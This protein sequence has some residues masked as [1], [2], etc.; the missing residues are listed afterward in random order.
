MPLNIQSDGTYLLDSSSLLGNDSVKYIPCSNR[1]K[2][3]VCNGMVPV[4]SNLEEGNFCFACSLNEVIPDLRI[5]AHLPLWKHLE[6][7]KRRTVFT[8]KK[9]KLPIPTIKQAPK[10]GLSFY[11][12][13]DSHAKDHF[14]IKL[15]GL[16]PVF[17][18]H[19]QGKIT[20][21]LAEADEVSRVTVKNSLDEGYRTLLG[22]FRHEIG[23][24]YWDVLVQ[25]NAP[26]LEE[27]RATFGDDRLDYQEAMKQHYSN[28]AAADWPDHF[29]SAYATMHPWEDWAET[30][31]HYLHMVDCLSTAES[32]DLIRLR[33][34]KNAATGSELVY[35]MEIDKLVFSWME[36]SV[37]LNALNR[38]MGLE[39][40]YPFVL[41]ASVRKKLAFIHK[42]IN[43]R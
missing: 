8:L 19:D 38:S 27:C 14:Q 20:I 7:A 25:N 2:Y 32:H 15:P 26:L 17:T 18:G 24:F 21:N 33:K 5:D 23:H 41:N 30:W 29:V 34:P 35:A 1:E 42:V 28:G 13:A 6:E 9:L 39:D 22:H 10:N 31:S 4:D 40:A 43:T 11:F 3:S 37:K 16:S 12:M 36:F